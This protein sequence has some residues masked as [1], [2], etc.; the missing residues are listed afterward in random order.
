MVTWQCRDSLYI[1]HNLQFHSS[2]G[3]K[4]L[5][6][7]PEFK[8]T[9]PSATTQSYPY[10]PRTTMS[11]EGALQ[12]K[13][14]QDLC[15]IL[16]GNYDYEL[17]IETDDWEVYQCIVRK[18]FGS[19]FGPP[20]TMTGLC[21]SEDEAWNELERMLGLW[22]TQVQSGQPMTMAQR[23][24]IFGGPKGENRKI[25]ELFEKE[26]SEIEM[27]RRNGAGSTT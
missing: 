1:T 17:D 5:Q 13:R 3:G 18:D 12:G 23:L 11:S 8:S 24:D 14:I 16:W 27:K 6:I 26:R 10:N 19:S 2:I 4:L 7:Y 21:N 15:Q 22:A 20:L 9:K 25:L